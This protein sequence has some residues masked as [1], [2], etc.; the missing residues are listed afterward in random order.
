M[1]FITSTLIGVMILLFAILILGAWN[2]WPESNTQTNVTLSNTTMHSNG[3]I[4]DISGTSQ[5]IAKKYKKVLMKNIVYGRE[6]ESIGMLI[7][8]EVPRSGPES[9]SVDTEGNV[10]IADTVNQRIQVYSANG[11]HQYEIT[12]KEGIVASDVAIDKIGHV[13]IYDDL[14]GKLYQYDKKGNLINTI[15]VD[16]KRWQSRGPMHIIDND[17]YITNSDQEDVLIGRIVKGSLL[18]LTK[19]DLSQPSKRG[20]KDLSGRRYFVKV[21]RL[22]KGEIEIYDQNG[23]LIISV[24]LPLKGIVSIKF[25]QEDKNGNFYIQTEIAEPAVREDESGKV[26]LEVHKFSP[27]GTYLSTILIPENDYSSWSVK[28]LSVDENGNIYQFLPARERGYLNIF[29]EEQGPALP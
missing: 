29:Q 14:Q 24:I 2:A 28:L 12:L 19:D 25:L 23:A 16:L 8:R 18:P 11:N 9:F 20:I 27:D 4:K 26:Q 6:K 5:G 22:E 10:Y 1:K 3:S 7:A 15:S 21:T 13:Y 17:I